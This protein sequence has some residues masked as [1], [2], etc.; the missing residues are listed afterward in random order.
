[1]VGKPISK[2]DD[3]AFTRVRII[4]MNGIG[5]EAQRFLH[6]GGRRGGLLRLAVGVKLLA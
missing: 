4:V 6:M 5:L 2:L 3:D 1:M